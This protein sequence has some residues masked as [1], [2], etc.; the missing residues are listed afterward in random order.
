MASPKFFYAPHHTLVAAATPHVTA[1]CIPDAST[2]LNLSHS[3]PNITPAVYKRDTSTETCLAFLSDRGTGLAEIASKHAELAGTSLPAS[4]P[5]TVN[6]ADEDGLLS[7]FVLIEP[8]FANE[9]AGL[10][11]AMATCGDF[12]RL[13]HAGG[14]LSPEAELAG[15]LVVLLGLIMGRYRQ[16]SA[17]QSS[18]EGKAPY[19]PAAVWGD[20]T[21][22]RPDVVG[23]L[24]S[25]LLSRLS[26]LILDVREGRHQEVW[27]PDWSAISRT[28]DLLRERS[29]T[30]A[31]LE[32][33]SF[34]AHPD[35][36]YASVIFP[37]DLVLPHSPNPTAHPSVFPHSVAFLSFLP[38]EHERH[39]LLVSYRN[40]PV[41]YFRYE[42]RVRVVSRRVAERPASGFAALAR[43]LDALE[44][45]HG[46][47][48]K[49]TGEVMERVSPRL[50]CAGPDGEPGPSRVPF[51]DLDAGVVAWLR[52]LDEQ[53]AESL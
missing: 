43:D 4:L 42:S 13:A 14:S 26:G 15:K 10:L 41:L 5:V 44:S 34:S 30:E 22:S 52:S 46:G 19:P 23:D 45:K 47:D 21:K 33:L 11:S 16:P 20:G 51:A 12:S 36:D 27:G 6:H 2:L 1:D 39:R 35:L 29:V 49:W 25:D 28:L 37:G 38:R 24:Y 32:P 3:N 8:A 18:R 31:G 17:V 40:I 9:N 48:G 7:L 53:P 50:F